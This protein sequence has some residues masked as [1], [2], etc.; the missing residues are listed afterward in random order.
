MNDTPESVV[1]RFLA[2]WREPVLDEFA[3]FFCYE[4][5]YTDGPRCQNRGSSAI[6]SEFETGLGSIAGLTIDIK[7]LP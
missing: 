4:A 3:S 5:I 6:R 1:R 7:A 2:A